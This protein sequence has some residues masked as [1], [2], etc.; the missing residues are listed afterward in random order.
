MEHLHLHDTIVF[1]AAAG[2]VIPA[3][4]RLRVSPVLGFLLIGTAVGPH[5]L[6]RFVDAYPWLS[7]FLITDISGVKALAELGI[8]FLL[9][10]I[11]LELSLERLWAIRRQVFGM[12]S[13]QILMTALAIG[14]IAYF[15]GNSLQVSVLLGAC[16]ALSSTAVVVQILIEQGRFGTPVGRGCFAVLLAQ[17]IAVVPILFLVGTFGAGDGGSFVTGLLQALLEA[18]IAVVL[19][20]GLGRLV[21]RPLFR[22]V[23]AAESPELFMAVTLLLIIATALATESAGMSAALGAF[24]AGLL[25]AESE[26]RHEIEINVEPFKGL[27]LGLF[28][29]SVGMAIDLAEV[30]RDPLWV[31]LSIVGLFGLKAVIMIAVA[32]VSGCEW[33]RAVEMGLL[34]GQGGEFAFVVVAL[35]VSLELMP[36]TTA[37]F[38]LIV[39]GATVFLTPFVAR[40]AAY[41]GQ[42]LSA[43]EHGRHAAGAG[44]DDVSEHVVIAGYGRTGQLLAELLSAQHIPYLAID[45][46]AGQ[47]SAKRAAGKPV[48]FGDASRVATLEKAHLR[49]ALALAVCIDDSEVTEHVLNA[50]RRVAP[51]TRIVARARDADHASELLT[52]GADRVVPELLESGLQLG[53]VMLESIGFPAAAAR[54]LIETHRVELEQQTAA[55]AELTAN[56]RRS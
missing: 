18:A 11:G 22:F 9:F 20:M 23:G 46:D 7:F 56:R 28:F 47:V 5:G 49:D 3:V 6:S 43:R 54:E 1:L 41:L 50:A 15:F 51:E 19:I 13:S 17:D 48:L 29:M 40:L 24:L 33:S 4:K 44:L 42:V 8:V 45:A 30:Y 27:L 14:G 31:L 53:H 32:R 25:L 36:T 52:A 2:L 37:Q 34:L 21:V 38:M 16:L 26:Y 55:A 12:G 35:A 39:V 10:A